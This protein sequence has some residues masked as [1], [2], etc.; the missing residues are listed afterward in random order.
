MFFQ[1]NIKFLRERSKYS[2]EITASGL[3]VNRSTLNNYENGYAQPK[4]EMLSFFS[5]YYK[6]SIDTLIHINLSRLSESQL[7]ELET[8]NDSYMRGTKLRVLATTVDNNNRENIELVPLKAKAGYTAGYN[9]PEFISGLPTFQLPFLSPDRKYRT[10]QIDGD[11]MLPI[12]N[13]SYVTG[14]FLTNWNDIKDGHAYVILTLDDGIVF[15]VAYNQPRIKK[16]LLLRSL[17]H[18]YKP[19]EINMAEIKEMWKFVY[20]TS[21]ELPEPVVD[22]DELI[23]TVNHLNQEVSQL[24]QKMEL[25]LNK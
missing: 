7:K 5:K 3:G 18:L 24:M 16:K 21:P 11:S 22:R 8:G 13:K 4:L 17:N 12:P 6:M 10:F 20:Y 9:D 19:Y 1:S 14:E 23:T 15:K 25:V 2:Q